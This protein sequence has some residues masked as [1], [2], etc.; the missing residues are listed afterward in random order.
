M[1]VSAGRAR[2]FACASPQTDNRGPLRVGV[3]N[4]RFQRVGTD[5][6]GR[7]ELLVTDEA[8]ERGRSRPAQDD[9]SRRAGGA[10][11]PVPSERA[12]AD[13]FSG[14]V[15]VARHGKVLLEDAWGRA[16]RE[17]GTAEHAG[18]AVPASAR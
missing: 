14:A 6:D 13:Q 5:A 8:V 10:R 15:L 4:I 1:D 7:V 17:S 2:R 18:H 11:R 3:D 16:D 9:R 12:A